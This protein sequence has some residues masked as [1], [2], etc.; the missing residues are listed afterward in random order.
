[1]RNKPLDV[2]VG[3][4]VALHHVPARGEHVDDSVAID[5]ASLLV[6]AVEVGVNRLVAGAQCRST[7]L[8]YQ[9]FQT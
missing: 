3:Q 7:G 2:L 4:V 5:G 1:M 8:I 9:M 6:N